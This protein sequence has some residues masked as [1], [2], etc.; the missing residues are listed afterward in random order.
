M[1]QT[2]GVLDMKIKR[3]IAAAVAAFSLLLC[4][5]AC[6]GPE[7]DEALILGTWEAEFDVT[8][9]LI[10]LSTGDDVELGSYFEFGEYKFK[11]HFTFLENGKMEYSFDEESSREAYDRF[12]AAYKDGMRRFCEVA[13][14]GQYGSFDA[15]CEQ[16]NTTP[17]TILNGFLEDISADKMF[18]VS[19]GRY[20]VEDGKILI[21]TDPKANPT[22]ST[23]WVYTEL[24]DTTLS[25]S[26]SYTSGALNT[27][28]SF[29]KTFTRVK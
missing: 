27:S 24:S 21:S 22:G 13:Y 11:A 7:G 4:V 9:Q 15:F 26:E 6:S 20:K 16:M 29:P 2:K 18:A 12:A 3:H 17:E 28:E 5:S 14:A 1:V 19:E 25:I 10:S 8:E 23:Y